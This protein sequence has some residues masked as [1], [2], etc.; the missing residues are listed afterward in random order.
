MGP[1]A[2]PISTTRSAMAR[3]YRWILNRLS[4]WCGPDALVDVYTGSQ[5]GLDDACLS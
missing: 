2:G 1:S 3:H 5:D 4:R